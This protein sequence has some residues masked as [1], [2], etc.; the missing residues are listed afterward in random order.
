MKMKNFTMLLAALSVSTF[1]NAQDP[2]LN[3]PVKDGHMIIQWDY[4]NG[5][6]AEDV[7][8][9]IDETFVY[10]L[11]ITGTP[12]VDWIASAP[13]GIT[14][15]VGCTFWTN[16]SDQGTCD[17]R[18]IN[19]KGNI[20]GATFNLKQFMMVRAVDPMLGLQEDGTYLAMTPGAVTEIYCNVFGF[21]WEGEEWGKEWWQLAMPVAV[22]TV[23]LP[24][25]GTKTGAEFYKDDYDDSNF[26][27][28]GFGDWQGYAAP[29]VV[30]TA[31]NSKTVFSSPVVGYE[32]YNMVG[33][34]LAVAPAKGF[35]IERIVRAD[36]TSESNK[37]LK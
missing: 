7:N 25:T 5:K 31:I 20:Y 18:L 9:E 23:T 37:I 33:Q 36:G 27:P 13:N 12:L 4:A 22:S 29:G 10:A 2:V 19:I 14:R 17:A 30:P 3:N 26:F 34:K 6:F 28:G 32:Y 16:Y 1:A 15:S 35:Y 8:F 24:Y 11:D 21:G